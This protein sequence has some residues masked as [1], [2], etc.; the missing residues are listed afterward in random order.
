MRLC[1]RARQQQRETG[2]LAAVSRCGALASPFRRHKR[3]MRTLR[4]DALRDPRTTW[5]LHRPVQHLAFAL[6]DA[7]ERGIEG[8]DV[9]IIP[10]R[11][12][13]D[14]WRLR[15]HP[16]L[17]LAVDGEELIGAHRPHVDRRRF[18]PAEELGIELER[19]LE[20]PRVE[21][22]RAPRGMEHHIKAAVVT[23]GE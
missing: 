14:V 22:R 15:H 12:N 1:R 8:G 7:P 20:I 18:R 19:R 4:I 11:R 6:G 17:V 3:E 10:P 13:G 21:L 5:Y 16:A 2:E 23:L 9:E